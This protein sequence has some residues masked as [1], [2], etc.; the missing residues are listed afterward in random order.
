MESL[1]GNMDNITKN[2]A[3]DFEGQRLYRLPPSAI[4]RMRNR[5]HTR[6]FLVT[7]LGYFPVTEGHRVYRPH[8]AATHILILVES[9]RGWAQQAGLHHSLGPG[10]AILFPPDQPHA[11]G[12][13][14]SHPWR[15]YWFHFA[16]AGAEALIEWTPFAAQQAVLFCPAMDALRRHFKSILTTVERGYTDH[17]LLNLSRSLIN[18]LSLL[19]EPGPE[20]VRRRLSMSLEEV[21]DYMRA[22]VCEPE[23][24]A[25]YARRCGLSVSRFS[26]AFREHTG[27]SPMTYFTEL[28]LQ[29][30]C[31][32][33]DTSD[34]RVGE[35]AQFLG[36]Q[37][38][39][40]FSR[41]FRKHIG[42]PPSIFRK[43]GI[44]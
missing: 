15:I 35:I 14:P 31:E 32:L 21:M 16:G 20:P 33:L 18:I 25:A 42:V 17:C 11:Y 12:A 5:P 10:Q 34:L 22:H 39:L 24:L 27:V 1:S 29:R 44:G 38:A 30:A 23:L 6:D 7:D 4:Q 43:R 36:F 8:G 3:E 9:G 37:D 19:H 2:R 40:Y 26:E 13:D 41:L 28:R